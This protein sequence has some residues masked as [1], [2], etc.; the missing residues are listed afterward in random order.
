M[1]IRRGGIYWH[2]MRCTALT[3]PVLAI[4]SLVAAEDPRPFAAVAQPT[5][6]AMA[7][8]ETT[9]PWPA[10][11]IATLQALVAAN[12]IVDPGPGPGRIAAVDKP[13][14]AM[15]GGGR[16]FTGSE[17]PAC[18]F[19]GPDG[20]LQEALVSTKDQ[21]SAWYPVL[22][23]IACTWN[24]SWD[25][26]TMFA[27]Q[28][29]RAMHASDGRVAWQLPA[30]VRAELASGSE[31][32]VWGPTTLQRPFAVARF[33]RD[34]VANDRLGL[35][36]LRGSE[37]I[38]GAATYTLSWLV[39]TA[40]GVER[41]QITPPTGSTAFD[42]LQSFSSSNRW[43]WVP[44]GVA[45]LQVIRNDRN[46]RDI[47]NATSLNAYLAKATSMSA[48]TID[49]GRTFAASIQRF[50]DGYVAA[51]V[52]R[53]PASQV[54]AINQESYPFCQ[55][56]ERA[57]RICVLDDQCQVTSSWLIP[58]QWTLSTRLMRGD[59]IALI[60]QAFPNRNQGKESM[61]ILCDPV[62][63]T[64]ST[65]GWVGS[66]QDVVEDA[67]WQGQRVALMVR[68]PSLGRPRWQGATDLVLK[69]NG[70]S[71]PTSAANA[72]GSAPANTD[73]VTGRWQI[74][75]G[76]GTGQFFVFRQDGTWTSPWGDFGGS[77]SAAPSGPT[78][79]ANRP[80]VATLLPDGRMRVVANVT[81]VLQR[82]P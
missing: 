70:A 18:G 9:D 43:N 49:L 52:V 59:A 36:E 71:I 1:H 8:G 66:E 50:R 69:P 45:E 74:V 41:L 24:W 34:T 39:V 56:S 79:T 73:S 51:L 54:V 48:A 72:T 77:W 37:T 14:R 61:T 15:I 82:V 55:A 27:W 78:M 75:E 80:V 58:G 11:T 23:D 33:M 40:A 53:A 16:V 5:G 81:L 7:K 65:V 30:E 19:P 13:L 21:A 76:A 67:I 12:P 47:P 63:R 46:D 6:A 64:V 60:A 35:L 62:A 2:A 22:A 31:H 3:L 42:L 44:R 32:P 28:T 38:A 4:A 20:Y 17:H 29:S 57:T 26:S 10:G 25:G 68:S